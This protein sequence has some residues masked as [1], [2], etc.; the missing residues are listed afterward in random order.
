MLAMSPRKPNQAQIYRRVPGFLRA[1]R[2]QAGLTQR[3]LAA[4]IGKPH[5]W[6][7]RNET[8]SRRVDIAEFLLVCRGC[9]FDPHQALDELAS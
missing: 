7:V 2:E 8:G 5:W 9:E 4:R 3:E 6:V 1:C